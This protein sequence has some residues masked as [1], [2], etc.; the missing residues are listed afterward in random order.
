MS[1]PEEIMRE[2]EYF[3][4]LYHDVWE[5]LKIRENRTFQ[6]SGGEHRTH[7]GAG[8]RGGDGSILM[9]WFLLPLFYVFI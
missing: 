3:R 8:R 1:A 5:L 6:V 9:D 7:Q 2:I 4:L